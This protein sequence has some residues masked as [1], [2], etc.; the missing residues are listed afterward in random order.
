MNK[1]NLAALALGFSITSVAAAQSVSY[2]AT[3]RDF[4]S[5]STGYELLNWSSSSPAQYFTNNQNNK[6][7]KGIAGQ[8]GSA[9]DAQGRPVYSALRETGFYNTVPDA[10][11]F[12]SWWT[13]SANPSATV[14]VPILFQDLG[15]GVHEYNNQALWPIDGQGLGNETYAHNYHF[16]LQFGGT[17]QYHSDQWFYAASDDDL[18]VY[19]DR[20]LALDMGGIHGGIQGWLD[21]NTLGLQEGQFYSF[22]IFHAERNTPQAMLNLQ[23]NMTLVPEPGPLGAAAAA[24]ML[25]LSRRRRASL[26]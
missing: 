26:T 18:W 9:L 6:L 21:L 15:G 22:D 24:G 4:S 5:T 23:T 25:F 10:A 20:K 1:R 17:F 12:S 11:T 19:I 7:E 2:Q 16:T 13:N 3:V 14:T 8:L